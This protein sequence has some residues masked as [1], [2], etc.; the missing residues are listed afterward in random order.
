[1]ILTTKLMLIVLAG[2]KGSNSSSVPVFQHFKVSGAWFLAIFT[3]FYCCFPAEKCQAQSV[4]SLRVTLKQMEEKPGY[5]KDTSYLNLANELGYYLAESNPDSAL[6]FLDKQLKL[7]QNAKFR[8]GQAEV[9]KIYGN[10]FQAKGDFKGSLDY[11]NRALSIAKSAK[12]VKIVPGIL[13]NIGL[14]YF[15]LGN[16]TEALNTYFEAIK[17]AEEV[18]NNFVKAAVLNNIAYVYLELDNL[19]EAEKNY[20]RVLEI[21]SASGDLRRMVQSLNNI[22][23]VRLKQNR[24]V[25]AL[26]TLQRAYGMALD[27]KSDDL[28]EMSSRTLAAI[29][30]VLNNSDSAENYFRESISI[31]RQNNYGVPLVKSMIGLSDLLYKKGKFNEAL[32]YAV[33]AKEQAE[34]MGQTILMRD[35]NEKLSKIYEAEGNTSNALI[36]YK[37]F[38]QY[39]DSINGLRSKRVAATLEAEYEF[40]KKALRFEKESLRQWWLIF[41]AFA[42]LLTI[43]IILFIIARNRNRLNRA[44]HNL[45]E[46][47]LEIEQKNEAL[48]RTLGQLKEAQLQL[49]HAEKMASLGELTAG[50]A[51]EIKNPLNFV[52]NFSELNAEIISEIEAEMESGNLEEI[53]ELLNDLKGNEQKI[54]QHGKRADAIVKG[55][56]AHTRTSTGQKEP[57]DLNALAREYLRLAY[58]GQKTKTPDFESGYHFKPADDLSKIEL[59]PQE[60]GRVLFNLM[61]NAFLAVMERS[62]TAGASY[63]PLVEVVLKREGEWVKIFIRDNGTGIPDSIRSKIFQPFFTTRP[64]GQGTGLGLSLSYDI[65]KAHGGDIAVEST[66]V[67]PNA[68]EAQGQGSVFIISLP[69]TKV[70]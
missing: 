62:K 12:E 53:K 16:Y 8:K 19:D 29:Y 64:A 61:Q 2:Q 49:I 47:T 23:D 48:E 52:N 24:H 45:K 37:L 9:L 63:K 30:V 17:G 68:P 22:G 44:Y 66:V 10:A 11:Y 20:T 42:G 7:C 39:N 4:E 13:N 26:T 38:K 40:S 18:N 6:L 55:M 54:T 14:V 1:M 57:T 34:K 27:L 28:I 51:H 50:I 41:S 58:Q 60:I 25:E 21:D 5:E 69:V 31:S 33:E 59:I 32:G 3:F 56:L 46:K 35:A 65:V 36:S 43:G 67:P 70:A 15:N